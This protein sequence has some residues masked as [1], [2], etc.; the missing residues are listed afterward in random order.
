MEPHT[1]VAWEV[2]DKHAGEAPMLVVAT[3]HWS[4][5]P[6]DVVRGLKGLAPE[7]SLAGSE[8]DLLGQVEELAPGQTV[9]RSIQEAC[10]RDIRFKARV[11]GEPQALEEGLD[12][13]LDNA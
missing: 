13:W 5:F 9:P 2:A 7:T 4:K 8:S 1:A 3:A 11:A 6:A 10:S 12:E